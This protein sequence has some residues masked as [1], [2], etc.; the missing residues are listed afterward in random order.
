MNKKLIQRLHEEIC[1]IQIIDTHEHI[2]NRQ[3]LE[4]LG[5]DLAHAIELGYLKDDLLALGMDSDHILNSGSDTDT[6]I[7]SLIPLLKQT[8]NTTYYQSLFRALRDLH[9]LNSDEPDPKN[10]KAVYR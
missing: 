3:M 7:E 5:F 9:G 8:R 2:I 10:L 6:L 1:K 4:A